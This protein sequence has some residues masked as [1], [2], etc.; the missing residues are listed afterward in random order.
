MK[1]AL[2]TL[3]QPGFPSP[4][5]RL[6]EPFQEL[7]GRAVLY[8][9]MEMLKQK[10]SFSDIDVIIIQRAFPRP[11]FKDLCSTIL[12]WGKPVVYETDDLI[13]EVPKHHKK[14]DYNEELAGNMDW[15]ARSADIVTVSTPALADYYVDIAKRVIVLPNYLS[16]RLW[17]DSLFQERPV[18]QSRIRLGL[19]GSK[20]HDEDFALVSDLLMEALSYFPHVDCTFYGALPTGIELS[21][22]INLVPANYLYEQ[23]PARL[24]QIQI[25]IGM[26]PLVPSK[27]NRAKSNIKFLEYGFLGIPSLYADLEPYQGTVVHGENGML[28]AESESAWRDSLFQLIENADLRKQL[29]SRA[30]Q[31]VISNH[32]LPQ[33]ANKWLAMCELA[34]KIKPRP[35]AVFNKINY[36]FKLK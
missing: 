17:N 18:Q 35:V 13:Q 19:V 24:A 22:R 31:D 11:Q 8:N 26:V 16:P 32:M 12:T 20:N 4:Q 21:K 29:G 3:D 23:H 7:A 9:G 14:P 2:F 36:S 10:V 34:I 6:I 27:F 1:I 30:R 33:H 15:L 28:C 25:D 5:I